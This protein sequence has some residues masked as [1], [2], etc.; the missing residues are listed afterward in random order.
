[1]IRRIYCHACGLAS[2]ENLEDKADGWKYRKIAITAMVPPNHG[3]TVS[4]D[5]ETTFHPLTTLVCDNCGEEIKDFSR[6]Y[7]ITMWRGNEIP[8][9]WE[10]EY[11]PDIGE[12]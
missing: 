5:K 4:T 9:N 2:T 10:K 8:G 7:A 11:C 6:A 12:K 1:M 3:V